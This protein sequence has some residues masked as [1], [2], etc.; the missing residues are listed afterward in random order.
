MNR[1]L[2]IALVVSLFLSACAA[3]SGAEF[4][5]YNNMPA[6]QPIMTGV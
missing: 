6:D 3:G 5:G 1:S 2:M 4:R